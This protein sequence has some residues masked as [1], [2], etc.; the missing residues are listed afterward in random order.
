MAISG[1]GILLFSSFYTAKQA[2]HLMLPYN[3]P[4]L[5]LND[6]EHAVETGQSRLLFMEDDIF[7][8]GF[9]NQMSPRLA[10]ALKVHKPIFTPW[11]GIF[12]QISTNNA[13]FPFMG[14]VLEAQ[15]NTLPP[16]ECEKYVYF[17]LDDWAQ[18]FD[19]LIMRKGREDMLESMNVVV[20][21]RMSFGDNWVNTFRLNSECSAHIFPV[22]TPSVSYSPLKVVKISGALVFFFSF[23]GLAGVVFLLEV[24]LCTA[25]SQNVVE[26]A[27]QPFEF[28]VNVDNAVSINVRKAILVKCVEIMQ[29]IENDKNSS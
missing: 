12:E 10:K 14:K 13:I 17:T 1:F 6:I 11:E 18:T 16:H 24:L 23:L 19:S 4:V 22:Y 27:V 7:G 8:V 20:A 3:P 26:V 25:K 2:E 21:E 28:H 5:T 9:V 15:L 29:M